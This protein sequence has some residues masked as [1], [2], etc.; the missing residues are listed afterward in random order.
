[1]TSITPFLL[2]ALTK[3]LSALSGS[4]STLTRSM[5]K[6]KNK[7]TDKLRA[8]I[9][10]VL[11]MGLTPTLLS[12]TQVGRISHKFAGMMRSEASIVNLGSLVAR[13]IKVPSH[14]ERRLF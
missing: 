3:T 13:K 10:N 6:D 14:N 12:S 2:S 11:I 4:K 5:M 7:V 8:A 1:V 9:A